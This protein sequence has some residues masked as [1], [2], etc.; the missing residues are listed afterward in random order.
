MRLRREVRRAGRHDGLHS[1]RLAGVAEIAAL[2][3][4]TRQRAGRMTNQPGFPE[5]VQVLAMG[6]VWLEQD[7]IDYLA[8]PRKAGRPKN[9]AEAAAPMAHSATHAASPP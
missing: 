1:G 5:P 9:P 3:G 2:R 7:V 6:P 8:A 4:V